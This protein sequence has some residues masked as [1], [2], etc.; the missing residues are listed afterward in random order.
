MHGLAQFL[1]VHSLAGVFHRAEQRGFRVAGRRSGGLGLD[2]DLVSLHR[3]TGLDWHEVPIVWLGLPPVHGEPARFDEHLALGFERLS[4]DPGDE[5]ATLLDGTPQGLPLFQYSTRW[6]WPIRKRKA[7]LRE[8][9]LLPP[10]EMVADA[11]QIL[12][13]LQP[14]RK[15]TAAFDV[16]LASVDTGDA[17]N[18]TTPWKLYRGRLGAPLSLPWSP[19]PPS[20]PPTEANV[21]AEPTP[22]RGAAKVTASLSKDGRC[23]GLCHGL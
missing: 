9:E 17:A 14:V 3:L 6:V 5:V 21:L 19:P 12:L 7:K 8:P 4:R 20:P 1:V 11:A 15:E 18:A 10:I 22:R 16:E 13:T 2:A 23:S